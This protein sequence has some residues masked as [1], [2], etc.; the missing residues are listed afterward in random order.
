M[1]RLIAAII[2]VTSMAGA[3]RAAGAMSA[4]G[5]HAMEPCGT[6][7]C[8]AGPMDAGMP[9]GADCIDHCLRA[10][11]AAPGSAFPA[12]TLVLFAIA[13]A[14]TVRRVVPA[15]SPDRGSPPHIG[16]SL[17]TLALAGI[18]MRN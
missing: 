17:R 12:L 10:A 2:I 13:L 11:Q 9:A 14:A 3:F 15:E 18:V 5:S 7:I 6:G 8:A 4:M 1:K 16:P